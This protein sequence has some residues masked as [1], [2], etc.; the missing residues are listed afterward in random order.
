VHSGKEQREDDWALYRRLAP[1]AVPMRAEQIATLLSLIPFGVDEAFDVLDVGCGEGHLSASLQSCYPNARVV[2]LDGSSEMLARAAA[3]LDDAVLRPFALESTEWWPVIDDKNV[4]VSS[5]CLHHLDD[6]GKRRLFSEIAA[7]LSRRGALL[8]ADLVEPQRPE[9]RDL[10]EATWDRVAEQQSIATTG[11]RSLYDLFI[12][13]EWN[14]YRHPDAIDMPSPLF[15]QLQWLEAAGF[16]GVDCWWHIAGHAI[17]GGYISPPD[18]ATTRL[19]FDDA[20]AT[21]QRTLN[22]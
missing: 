19:R 21:A 4:V 22:L 6:S 18:A 16:T 7:R 17:Y 9:A 10:F 8:I 15:A 2:A 11:G 12:D 1:A 5:L 3:R 20:L 13:S 14:L